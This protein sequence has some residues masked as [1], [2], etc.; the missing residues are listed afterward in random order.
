VRVPAVLVSPWCE[1]GV[2]HA[3][4]D[5]CSVL[6]YL[7]DKWQLPPL[8]NRTRAAASIGLAVRCTGE[9]RTDTPA[10]IRVSNQSLIPQHVE[11]EKKSS[12]ANQHGLHHFAD[13]LHA[14]LDRL[15][16]NVVKSAADFARTEN[17]WVRFKSAF[18]SALMSV[19][20]WLSRDF[21]QAKAQREARTS[22][23]FTRLSQA[24]PGGGKA[25]QRDASAPKQQG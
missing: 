14:E 17:A 3:Q 24:A 12:N 2:C 16:S 21:Y 20:Q 6:K 9:P 13:H 23:A 4:F 22:R 7:C 19:G 11:L 25:P 8:G 5:H 10:Y 15:A 1:A 18:G